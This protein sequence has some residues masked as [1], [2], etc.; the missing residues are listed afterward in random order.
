MEGENLK[1]KWIFKLFCLGLFLIINVFTNIVL[2]KTQ[3]VEFQ[4]IDVTTGWHITNYSSSQGITSDRVFKEGVES[5]ELDQRMVMAQFAN[6]GD[7]TL[8]AERI[9]PMKAGRTYNFDLVFAQLYNLTGSGYIDFNGERFNSTNDSTPKEF[10]RTITPAEDLDYKIEV[11]FDVPVNSNGYFKIAFDRNGSGITEEVNEL[12]APVITPIPEA[13]TRIVSGTADAGNEIVVSDASNNVIG[14]GEVGLDGKFSVTT[15]RNLHFLEELSV[16][17]KNEEVESKPTKV[18]VTKTTRPEAPTI[19]PI[20][21]EDTV[22]TGTSEAFTKVHVTFEG[23]NPVVYE[24]NTDDEGKYKVNLNRTFPGQTKITAFAID[25]AGNKSPVATS[26]VSFAKELGVSIDRK[27]SSID[28]LIT[29]TTTRPQCEVKIHF[30]DRVYETVSDNDG[31]YSV[32]LD[33]VYTAGTKFDVTAFH[34]LSHE[35]ATLQEV[36]LPRVPNIPNIKAGV[37]VL[38]GEVDPLAVVHLT[39]ETISGDKF[40]YTA[41]AD[42]TGKFTIK[43]V[44][45]ETN[46]IPLK[47]GDKLTFFA[48]LEDINMSSE[49][50]EFE[51]LSR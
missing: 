34:S 33:Q 26:Q 4:T 8:T 47:V 12:N 32:I 29:G 15:N 42:V 43:L 22:L 2:S 11:H 38:E 10:K 49:I 13:G 37:D 28:K 21:D 14:Q 23:N 3:Q 20:T 24:V 1:K 41:V 5:E 40:E 19:T 16:I 30:G 25:E 48:N 36:V 46:S 51:V 31:K 45:N 50:I 7:A 6:I 17:Q 39:L 9:I 44:D 18:I 27:I 35:T